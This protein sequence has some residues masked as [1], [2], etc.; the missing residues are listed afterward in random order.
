MLPRRG[1]PHRSRACARPCCEAHACREGHAKGPAGS[2]EA[3][4]LSLVV[5]ASDAGRRRGACR[6]CARRE[7]A[8]AVARVAS[9]HDHAVAAPATPLGPAGRIRENVIS[10]HEVEVLGHRARPRDDHEVHGIERRVLEPRRERWPYARSKTRCGGRL[11]PLVGRAPLRVQA[12]CEGHAKAR[13]D[14]GERHD[15]CASWFAPVTQ[16]TAWRVSR[17]RT[18]RGSGRRCACRVSAR[19]RGRGARHSP[20]TCRAH[21]RERDL[22][23][24]GRGARSPCSAA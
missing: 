3:R 2:R 7:G 24:R 13:Q 5:R 23:S 11:L 14:R 1:G 10:S 6:V 20:R 21:S 9:A 22:E 17:L 12:R 15:G 4:P 19:P 16:Q 8:G 18:A